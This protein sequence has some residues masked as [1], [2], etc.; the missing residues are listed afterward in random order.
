MR[1]M[2]AEHGLKRTWRVIV[3]AAS[4]AAL[5]I[6]AGASQG[7]SPS[8]T[9]VTPAASC[10]PGT[11]FISSNDNSFAWTGGGLL[12]PQAATWTGMLVLYETVDSDCYVT[13]I[14]VRLTGPTNGGTISITGDVFVSVTV[15]YPSAFSDYANVATNAVGNLT[16]LTPAAGGYPSVLPTIK[17]APR[18]DINGAGADE[19]L[20]QGLGTIGTVSGIV[21]DFDLPLNLLGQT[22]H[23]QAHVGYNQCSCSVTDLALPGQSRPA[24][25]PPPPPPPPSAET[26]GVYIHAHEDD[27]QLFEAPSA[28]HDYQ[29]GERLLFIYVTAGDAGSGTSYWQ[30]REQAADASVRELAG[31]GLNTTSGSVNVC[32]NAGS[33]VCHSLWQWTYGTT[34]SIFMRLPD[35]GN[36]GGGFS[37]SGFESLSKLRDGNITNISAVD[38]STT[39]YGWSDLYQTLAAVVNAYAPND[40][41]TTIHAPEF[42]RNRQTS[43]GSICPGCLDHADH[44]AVADAVANATIGMGAPWTREFFIDYAIAFADPRY[45]VNQDS[46]NYTIKKG[47]FTAYNETMVQLTGQNAYG[48]MPWFYENA[49][50]REYFRDV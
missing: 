7:V 43:Q 19:Y 36:M 29:S 4:L 35:G 13:G 15:Q 32:Y 38:A 33:Q 17:I 12:S 45:P 47:L 16:S 8:T 41:T 28:Y 9:G 39:Y 30:A 50:Q 44:L 2:W 42:D 25:P 37:T 10:N 21:A 49:F 20:V 5:S 18:Y 23:V 1:R 46:A 34:V 24:P 22:V 26:W 48:A 27:W 14:D 31:P 11:Y 6:L 3:L 40:S